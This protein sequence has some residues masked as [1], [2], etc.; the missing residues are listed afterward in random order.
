ME[1]L[2]GYIDSER[3]SVCYKNRDKRKDSDKFIEGSI[4]IE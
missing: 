1:R 4:K 3:K 2:E